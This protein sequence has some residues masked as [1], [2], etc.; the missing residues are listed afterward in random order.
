MNGNGD[1]IVLVSQ[2]LFFLP[3]VYNAA[4]PQGYDVMQAQTAGRFH[5][6]HGEDRTAL[7]LVDLAGDDAEW[8]AIV[9]R[10]SGEAGRPRIIA[11]GNHADEE[12]LEGAVARGCDSAMSNAELS[13]DIARIIE[14]L[15]APSNAAGG[16]G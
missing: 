12:A 13:R 3:R 10:L 16:E 6:I 2:D 15:A 7:V 14:S 1:R 4:A 8:Q 11:F 9:E 5:D